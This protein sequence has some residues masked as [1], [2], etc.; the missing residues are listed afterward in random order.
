[1]QWVLATDLDNTLV[2]DSQ[3][4]S[5]LN[6]LLGTHRHEV[7]LVYSTGRSL[8]SYQRLCAEVDLL[9]PDAIV[10]SVGT[11]IYE[12]GSDR[13]NVEWSAQLQPNWDRE[14][15]QAI[16]QR[17]AGLM[18]QEAEAQRPFK[19]SYYLSAEDA[20]TVLPELEAMLKEKGLLAQ[21]VY[22]SGRDLDILPQA[23]DKGNA[24]TFVRERVSIA[25]Q[26][27]VACGDSGN[28]RA[29]FRHPEQRGIIVGNA[30]PELLDW[31]HQDPSPHR[32]LAKGHCAA[33]ILEGLRYFQFL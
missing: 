14:L 12:P 17:F 29:F 25:R 4:L 21:I 30:L 6:A 8:A 5:A 22:S 9:E 15:V 11:E 1:M 26:R 24:M 10:T 33:G 13:P 16:A 31:H 2:G 7:Y 32:Y 19:V 27:S 3:A 23:A 20:M 28:D 18:P